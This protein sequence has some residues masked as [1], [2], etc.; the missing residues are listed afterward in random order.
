MR[1]LSIFCFLIPAIVVSQNITIKGQAHASYKGKEVVLHDFTDYI[2]YTQTTEATDTVDQNGYFELK[3]H[4]PLTKPILI[5]IDHVVGKL[6]VQPN[7]V[8]GIYF[9][10]RDTSLDIRGDADS[11]VNISVYGRDSTELNA[12]IID[13]NTLYNKV[14][15]DAATRYLSPA[16]VYQKLDT[17]QILARQRYK[18]LGKSYF[19]DYVEY[20]IAGFNA[21]AARSRNFLVSRYISKKPILYDNYEYME[22]FDAIFKDYLKSFATMHN[23]GNIYN[24]INA[25]ADYKDMERQ[26]RSDKLI[27]NDTLR[28]LIILKELTGFYYSPDFNKQS[29]LSML[30]QL[31]RDTKIERHRSIVNQ[32]LQN[33]YQL[34]PGAMAPVFTATDKQGKTISLSDFKGRFV[35]INFFNTGSVN[36]LMEMPKIADLKKKYNDKVTFIS[37][38]TDDSLKTYKDYLK[39]NPKFDW[40]ILFNDNSKPRSAKELYNIKGVPAFFFINVAG[41]LAQSPA[42]APSQGIEYKFKAL[43]RPS[44]KNT[45]PGI[46]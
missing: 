45:I 29:V 18:G 10:Q 41:Q 43:F 7:Y 6:Y 4:S 33:I 31:H 3:F 30:E 37:I 9:P 2:S 44:K 34:Q 1:I 25:F 46:R 14:F 15:S 40:V 5:S 11:P 13:F 17:L 21:N 27:T 26:F 42:Q 16:G 8:Y 39:A 19:R 35:Y 28:E 32:V 22:F 36:S 20:S 23:G 38:C 12:L 24:S